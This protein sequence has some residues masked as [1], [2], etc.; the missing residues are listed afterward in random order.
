MDVS[1]IIPALNEAGTINTTI[2]SVFNQNVSPVE[3]I[4]VDGDKKGTTIS[5]I[6]ENSVKSITSSPG[7]SIQMNRGAGEATGDILLFLHSDTTLPD[8]ALKKILHTIKNE[9]YPA[10]A[11]NLT[12]NA[13]GFSF[14][15]VEK[16]ASL[17]SRLTRIPFGDQAIFIKRD[18]FETLDGYTNIPVMEDLD[19][20]KRIKKAGLKIKLLSPGIL[21]SARR[22]KKEGVVYCTVRNWVILF[23][24]MIGISPFKLARFYK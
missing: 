15:V 4:V 3:V 19:L 8:N 23:F 5:A 24:F 11:F 7:R 13:T 12:I 17:R 18:L 1:I 6:Q 20:M 2:D 9:N 16:M 21:T 14:R 10:G 22:W